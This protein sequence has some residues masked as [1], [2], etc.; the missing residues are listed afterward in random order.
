MKGGLALNAVGWKTLVSLDNEVLGHRQGYVCSERVR[1]EGHRDMT[2]R[3]KS[4]Q[5][6]EHSR[7]SMPRIRLHYNDETINGE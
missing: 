3:D 6:V 2:R 1:K 5:L 7:M 4:N